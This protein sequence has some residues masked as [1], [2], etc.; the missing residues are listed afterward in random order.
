MHCGSSIEDFVNKSFGPDIFH[1][2]LEVG[3]HGEWNVE[4]NDLLCT[5]LA[6]DTV[7][8]KGHQAGCHND[9]K[10]KMLETQDWGTY[11]S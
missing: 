3:C 9:T 11:L 6:L 8:N 7:V 5:E 2:H 1:V 4:L 10:L